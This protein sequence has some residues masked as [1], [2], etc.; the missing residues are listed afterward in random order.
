[1]KKIFTTRFARGT[2]TPRRKEREMQMCRAFYACRVQ[3]PQNARHG[4]LK[5]ETARG[6]RS[7]SCGTASSFSLNYSQ[8]GCE[9]FGHGLPSVVPRLRDEGGYDVDEILATLSSLCL[10]A[11]SEAGGESLPSPANTRVHY[12]NHLRDTTL[13]C[14]TKLEPGLQ[15][16]WTE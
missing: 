10:C 11:S 9:N 15:N 6:R 12:T 16:R 1:M 14:P 3:Q 8:R 4:F 5:R 2:E 7:P 13:T